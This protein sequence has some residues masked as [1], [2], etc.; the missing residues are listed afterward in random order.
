MH[1]DVIICG[2]YDYR[3]K[4]ISRLELFSMKQYDKNLVDKGSLVE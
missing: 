2:C 1:N 4:F 3:Q